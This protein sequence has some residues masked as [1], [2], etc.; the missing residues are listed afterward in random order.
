[1]DSTECRICSSSARILCDSYPST[2]GWSEQIHESQ[3][4]CLT[5][6]YVSSL[7]KEPYTDF[8]QSGLSDLTTLWGQFSISEKQ[9]FCKTYGD[10]ASFISIPIEEPVLRAALRFWDPS[11]RCFTFGKKDLVSTIEEYSVLIGIY[12]QYPDNVY[13]KKPRAGYRK[14][15]AKIL[16]VK[17]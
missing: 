3:G 9:K 8:T 10:I 4:D 12:L 11:H 5:K 13:N 2:Q 6:D 14:M 17:P 16:K 15:L 1:M 7:P